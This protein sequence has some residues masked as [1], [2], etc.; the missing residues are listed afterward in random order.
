MSD[1]PGPRPTYPI[2]SVDNALRL[3]LLFR[4]RERIGVAEA[5]VEIGVARSTAHR[6]LAMLIYRGFVVQDPESR[7]YMAGPALAQVGLAVVH[8]MDI[9]PV[10]RPHLE[11]L[12]DEI[13]ETVHLV[14]LRGG[15]VF[16][17]DCVESS[18]AVR[19]ASR[20]GQVLPAYSTSAGKALLAAMKPEE[21]RWLYA[22]LLEPVTEFTIRERS[23]LESE[24]EQ[25][26]ERGYATNSSESE[27]GV[28]S[29]GVAICQDTAP[30]GALS[31]AAPVDRLSAD[32]AEVAAHAAL[33]TAR[34]IENDL[35]ATA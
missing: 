2:E 19:V 7:Q 15:S 29:V 20:V 25:I 3:V 9:R 17:I 28:S 14:V 33:R 8:R 30:I 1:D 23:A 16:F 35:L 31:V 24:L 4:E 34:A 11:N 13:Q 26:R 21:V 10:A 22:E 6:L 12:A 32:Q 5:S 18:K 27:L